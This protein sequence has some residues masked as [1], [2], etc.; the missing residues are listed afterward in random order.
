MSG[1]SKLLATLD[2]KRLKKM[3][4]KGSDGAQ[5]TPIAGLSDT[6]CQLIPWLCIFLICAN[7]LFAS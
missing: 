3:S 1:A 6:T 2:A 4:A 5:V 7:T